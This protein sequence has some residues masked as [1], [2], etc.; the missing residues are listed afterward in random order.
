VGRPSE[1]DYG[2]SG[3]AGQGLDF[4]PAFDLANYTETTYANF[5]TANVRLADGIQSPLTREFTVGLGRE[6]GERGH[7]KATYAWRRASQFVED[8]L[9]L[10]RGVTSVPLVGPLTNRVYDNTDVLYRDYQALIVQSAYRLFPRLTVDGN[11]TLQLR[12]NGTFSGEATNQPGISS[13]YG[14]FPEIFGPALDRLL[15]EG[16]LDNYQQHKLRV[17]T[18]YQQPLGRFGS[19]DVV[20]LWRVNSGGVYSLTSAIRVP[21][22]QLA[23]NPGYPATDINPATRETVYFGDRGGYDFK[24]YG[25]MDLA[26]SYNLA[27]WKSARPWVKLEV[28]NLFNNQKQIAWDKTVAVDPASA[29][30]ANGI[31]TGYIEG[32]QFGRAT[33]GNQFPQPYLGQNGGRA[34]KIAFGTRF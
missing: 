30:D 14:N 1:V 21:A 33:N 16:R 13:I 2:Y 8:F 28:Y 27:V 10:S 18:I 22:V 20:P 7:A 5:P 19:V 31:P 12:N 34:L 17:A 26:T 24:G 15:P 3:P 23:R 25:V 9:D 29:R 11:Y 6:L 4:A 32:A